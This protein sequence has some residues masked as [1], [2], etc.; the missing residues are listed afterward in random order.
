MSK[1]IQ[2]II[3]STRSNRMADQIASWVTTQ[4]AKNNDINLEVVDLK[5]VNLPKFDTPIPPAY[6]PID[7]AEAKAWAEKIDSADGYIFLTPEYNRSIPAAL[8][9][10]LDYLVA[11]WKEKPAGIISYGWIDG[12]QSASNHL[13]DILGWLKV[14]VAETNAALHLKAEIMNEQGAIADIDKAFAEYEP[15]VADLFTHVAE[16][17][18]VTTA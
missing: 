11:E 6:A 8:K 12:G 16:D 3:A 5:K 13:S 15:V 17:V 9:S 18:A 14:G 2:L 4:A 10:A 1:N 7:T